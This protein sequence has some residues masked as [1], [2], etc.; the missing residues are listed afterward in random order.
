MDMDREIENFLS[1]AYPY[2]EETKVKYRRTLHELVRLEL[3]L[4]QLDAAGLVEFVRRP[5][6]GESQQHVVLCTCRKF[7]RWKYGQQHPATFAKIKRGKSKK[8]PSLDMVQSLALLALFDPYTPKGCRDLAIS[9][10]LLDT[11]LRASEVSRIDLKNVD[12]I[13][14]KH[15]ILDIYVCTLQVVIKGGDWSGAVFSMDTSAQLQRWLL[16]R[17]ARPGV[18]ALF[19]S[20]TTA[21]RLTKAGVQMVYKYLDSRLGFHVSPHM[22]RRSFTELTMLFGAP[23]TVTQHAGRWDD[24]RMV[25]LYGRNIKQLL[26]AP[27]LP[28]TNMLKFR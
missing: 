1:S 3:D 13:P 10:L 14:V 24:P 17:R 27:Y 5:G 23:D 9:M 28:V 15:P 6:W 22:F 21:K 18:D 16:L 7:L 12:F 2:A 4:E 25:A 8:Q 19:T 11:G 26:I 20:V